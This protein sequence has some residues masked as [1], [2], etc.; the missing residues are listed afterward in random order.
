MAYSKIQ[1]HI[2]IAR[3]T[4]KTLSSMS[5]KSVDAA[6]ELLKAHYATV[7]V[8]TINTASDLNRLV[9]KRPDLVFMGMKY[10][11]GALPGTKI[12]ISEYLEDHGIEHTGSP[13]R[14]I[15]FE[16]NKP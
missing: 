11:Y 16:Q 10:V 1:K 12:W 9:A 15:E 2:E 5:Q 14:A 6:Y 13:K 4:N 8:T 3:S 7:G